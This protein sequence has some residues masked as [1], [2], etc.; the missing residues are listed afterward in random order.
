MNRSEA[1]YKKMTETPIPRLIVSLGIP[2][3]ISMLV[4]NIYNMADTFFVGQLKNTSASAAVGVVF[5]YM[6]VIQAIGF[7]FGQG[8]GSIISRMLGAKEEKKASGVASTAFFLALAVGAVLSISSLILRKPL[9]HLLGSS[10]TI[11]PFAKDYIKFI[12]AAA[13]ITMGSFVL[14]NILRYE[15]KASLAMIGLCTGSLINIAIDPVF[16]FVLDMGIAGA[17]LATALSQ[18]ISFSLLLVMFLKGKTQCRLKVQEISLK[19]MLVAD[20]VTT[21]F[22][23]FI[24]Q[25]LTS[26][27]TM[28]LN[29]LARGYGDPA[30]AAM[31]IVNRLAFFMFAIGLGMGQGYQPVC[32]FNYGAKKY[33]RVKQAFKF[34]LLVNEVLLGCFAIIG[35]TI[36]PTA[37]SWFRNDPEVIKIGKTA[38]RFACCALFLQ[39]LIVMSNMTFQSTGHKLLASF[40]A[41]LRSGLYFIPIIAVSESLVGL[42]GIQFA[43]PLADVLSFATVVP[44]IIYFFRNI[45]KAS[46]E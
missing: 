1:Q 6:A 17:G 40:T 43:Q 8:A 3:V 5:G 35:F 39:P 24:R 12:M 26:I 44:L 19:A 21:G 23:A 36:A 16:M 25:G 46:Q 2:T 34:T 10:D 20:I 41:M 33:D 9:L 18:C 37:V 38:L 13:P 30:I 28:V 45:D 29:R 14:N 11:Y 32:G 27:S 7:M 31:S 15:G 22:P 42:P 4:T